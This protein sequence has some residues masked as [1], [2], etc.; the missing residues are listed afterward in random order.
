MKK[1]FC[2]LFIFL[3]LPLMAE[4]GMHTWRSHIAYG[5]VKQVVDAG[6][7]IYALAG[8]ALMRVD[9]QTEEM[10]CYSKQD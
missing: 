3:S 5:D 4:N 7:G 1:I 2:I 9:K 6:D 10:T 8:N